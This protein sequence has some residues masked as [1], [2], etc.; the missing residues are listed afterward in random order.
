MRAVNPA[1]RF[2][3]E[4]GLFDAERLA[5]GFR[6]GFRPAAGSTEVGNTRSNIELPL[7]ET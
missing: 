5:S 2:T 7:A 1:V 6:G 3:S 4:E